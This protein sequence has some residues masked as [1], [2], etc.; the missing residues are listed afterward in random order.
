M[1]NYSIS[2]IFTRDMQRVLLIKKNRPEWQKGKLN[3]IGG[4]IEEG[5][6]PLEC[7][8]REVFEETSL[9][10]P[11]DNWVHFGTITNADTTQLS[12]FC[13]I[14]QGDQNDA[15]TSTDEE[16]AWVDTLMLPEKM[17][18]NLSWLIPL[19]VDVLQNKEVKNILVENQS[20]GHK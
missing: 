9:K 17:M 18:G 7:I 8:V 11:H 20:V 15:K 6:T 19:A 12:L 13:C 2:F 14:Y 10:I 1:K 4:H 16:I 3:G 5:E